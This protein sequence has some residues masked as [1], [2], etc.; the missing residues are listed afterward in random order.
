MPPRLTL[1][2]AAAGLLLGESTVYELKAT[3]G[4]RFALTVEK[5]GLLSGKKHLFLFDRYQGMLVYDPE[6]P[7]RSRVELTIDAGSAVC[8]DSWVSRNDLKKIQ[9]YA[10]HD[11]LAV[12]KYPELRFRSTSVVR[13]SENSFQVA[14]MLAIRG[15]ENPVTVSVT[16]DNQRGPLA[17]LAGQ[18]VVRLKDYGLKP[19]SAALGAIG[20]KNEMTV[21]F[22]LL[23]SAR[24]AASQARRP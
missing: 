5:T 20:T 13:K 9:D 19:P 4:S 1:L 18:A 8:K 22:L 11:M 12:E 21:E 7:E 10:L 23:P 6:T 15:I 24:A 2:L 14:G 16:V 3:S 17:S